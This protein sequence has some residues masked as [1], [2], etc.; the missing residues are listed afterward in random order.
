MVNTGVASVPF[1]HVL[2][3]SLGRGI[4]DTPGAWKRFQALGVSSGTLQQGV[5]TQSVYLMAIFD[6]CIDWVNITTRLSSFA[7]SGVLGVTN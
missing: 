1:N 2:E 7:H 4:R 3:P 6:N 5:A